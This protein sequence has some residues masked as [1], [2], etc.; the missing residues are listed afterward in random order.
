MPEAL[1]TYHAHF[2]S[3]ASYGVILWG[4]ST[5]APK[6][7]LKQKRAIRVLAGLHFTDSCRDYFKHY[8]ILTIPSCYILSC[9]LH[10]YD[11]KAEQTRHSEVHNHFTRSRNS[12]V[13]PRN[14]L[15]R[16]QNSFHYHAT[17]MYN[18]LP[19]RFQNLS[20][21][22]FKNTMASILKQHAFY[23]LKEFYACRFNHAGE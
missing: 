23:D 4:A 11:I 20:R 13:L 16:T 19:E 14:R 22:R 18:K 3:L 2:H 1:L 12:F 21:K 17:K 5:N 15:S 6:V 10:F 9:L 8:G 7:F